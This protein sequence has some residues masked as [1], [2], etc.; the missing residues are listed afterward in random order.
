MLSLYASNLPSRHVPSIRDFRGR[1]EWETST[2]GS[3]EFLHEMSLKE[4]SILRWPVDDGLSTSPSISTARWDIQLLIGLMHAYV[5]LVVNSK[6]TQQ[7]RRKLTDLCF[8]GYDW[9]NV[10]LNRQKVVASL[11][12]HVYFNIALTFCT[13]FSSGTHLVQYSKI[14]NVKGVESLLQGN[15][16]LNFAVIFLA[17]TLIF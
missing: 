11:C 4:W 3:F 6:R 17:M 7:N 13:K 8:V 12:K 14:L 5:S 1:R 2:S 9:E 15:A 16:F 10:P